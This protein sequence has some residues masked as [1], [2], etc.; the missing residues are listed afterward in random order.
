[1][2]IEERYRWACDTPSD[3][4]ALIPVLRKYG[5]QCQHV[6]EF[7]VRNCVS[8][9]AWL[10]ARPKKIV[11][12][13]VGYYPALVQIENLALGAGIEFRFHCESTANSKIHKTDLLFVDTVHN[14][15]QLSA[16]LKENH[17]AVQ[18]FMIFHDTDTYGIYGEGGAPDRKSVV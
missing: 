1:M 13:D 5:E 8:L 12:Y 4:S 16:E 10:A 2:T 14:A 17:Y 6:T 7:G 15:F 3:I 9:S 18:K 11:C